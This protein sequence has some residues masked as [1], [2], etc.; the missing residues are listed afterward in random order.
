MCRILLVCSRS[1][2]PLRLVVTDLD[3]ECGD[4]IEDSDLPWLLRN[5]SARRSC[6]LCPK[7]IAKKCDRVNCCMDPEFSGSC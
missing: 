7:K 1:Q 4:D 2:A 5:R 3:P 6:H